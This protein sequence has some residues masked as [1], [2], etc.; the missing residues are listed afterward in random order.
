MRRSPTFPARL[1]MTPLIDI[2]FLVIIFFMALPM[3]KLDGKLQ[4]FLPP[5]Q[6]P[7]PTIEPSP[8]RISIWVRPESYQIGDR[9]S[10]S[11]WDFQDL[12]RKLGPENSYSLRATPEVDWERVVEAVDVLAS[13]NYQHI[14]FY[15]TRSPPPSLRRLLRLPRPR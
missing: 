7:I 1:Q 11:A 13:L 12:L 6:G 15:G 2:A 10:D 3:R 14:E 8:D 4:A 9:T 5:T